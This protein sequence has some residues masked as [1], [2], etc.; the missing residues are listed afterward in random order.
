MK[1][2]AQQ[3]RDATGMISSG[4]YG[5]L[6]E[7]DILDCPLEYEEQSYEG[8]QLLDW[9]VEKIG[10]VAGAPS[11]PEARKAMELFLDCEYA[12][13]GTLTINRVEEVIPGK[14]EEGYL[15][16]PDYEPGYI[17]GD[18]T[19]RIQLVNTHFGDVV[20][21]GEVSWTGW[22]DGRRADR[23][24]AVKELARSRFSP[25]DDLIWDYERIPWNSDVEPEKEEI[26]CGEQMSIKLE[27]I[28]D[29]KG[30]APQPWQRIVVKVEK[31]ELLNGTKCSL[32][33]KLYAFEAEGGTLDLTYRA[34]DE[35]EDEEEET[36][37]VY[38][39]CDWGQE[40]MRPLQSTNPKKKIG[41]GHFKIVCNQWEGTIA[42]TWEMK[43]GEDE[44]VL[45]AIMHRGE[46]D[47]GKSWRIR[48]KLKKDRGNENVVIYALDEARL[49]SFSE[50]LEMKAM[51]ME[52][53]GRKIEMS[54]RDKAETRS[55]KLSKK[56][57][58]LEL[59]VNLKK[60]TYSIRGRIEVAGIAI[61]GESR[62]DI[63]VKPIIVD[64][65]EATGGTT[66]VKEQI[67]IT[68]TFK[69]EKPSRLN[70]SRDEMA[71]LPT[72]WKDFFTALAGKIEW[73]VSW[74]L[75]K[76]KND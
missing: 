64:E 69:D 17:F 20:R 44:S 54:G 62:L 63:K 5:A 56:E 10:E 40:W 21:E 49:E 75:R 27:N 33:E 58:D 25:V 13:K 45:A 15:G 72:E 42:E 24:S 1:M 11:D 26:G 41:E 67:E 66:G 50:T 39:S 57:C 73:K 19:L 18:W 70:G 74:D 47:A 68:G 35:A 29:D 4:W 22:A 43:A 32:E 37:T 71:N 2:P 65:R 55:R 31:G 3:E 59:A 53:E 12:W 6:R 61:D 14:W 8:R 7:F 9:M 48:V 36:I 46:Y 23:S 60:K 34:P 16:K 30:R 38:N 76:K 28:R 51:R 52:R